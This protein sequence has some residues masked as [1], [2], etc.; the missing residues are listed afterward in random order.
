MHY[1]LDG[2]NLLL[3][4]S[5]LPLNFTSFTYWFNMLAIKGINMELNINKCDG[6]IPPKTP[7]DD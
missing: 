5:L 7:R 6:I 4:L 2:G 3:V 1:E